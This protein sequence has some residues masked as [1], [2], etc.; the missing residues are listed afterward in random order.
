MLSLAVPQ[1]PVLCHSPMGSPQLHLHNP[2][3]PAARFA[4]YPHTGLPK[5]N[6]AFPIGD[7]LLSARA[8]GWERS[9][10]ACINQQGQ[11]NGVSLSFDF[12]LKVKM[13]HGERINKPT[14]KSRLKIAG[15]MEKK[16]PSAFS[17]CSVKTLPCSGASLWYKR[18]STIPTL[19]LSFNYLQLDPLPCHINLLN[20]P[21][22]TQKVLF[23]SIRCIPK[24]STPVTIFQFWFYYNLSYKIYKVLIIFCC[25]NA[26][27][28][29]EPLFFY[30]W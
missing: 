1:S 5:W 9:L 2:F 11:C 27:P 4:Q 18:V 30:H 28:L 13:I 20:C 21:D 26:F 22:L 16:R 24:D 17:S 12:H 6:A 23:V 7:S 29:Q 15:R 14:R 10:T 8:A 3:I 19:F 25:P